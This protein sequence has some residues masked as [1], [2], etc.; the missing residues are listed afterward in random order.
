MAEFKARILISFDAWLSTLMTWVASQFLTKAAEYNLR[1]KKC[2]ASRVVW[3]V[4]NRAIARTTLSNSRTLQLALMG[5]VWSLA[6]A[7]EQLRS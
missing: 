5:L 7:P 2:V 3:S 4:H 6:E 1:G